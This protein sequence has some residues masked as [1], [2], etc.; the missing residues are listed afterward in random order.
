MT[1]LIEDHGLIG[2]LHTAGL[3][4]R[5][6]TI[7]WLCLPRF[8]SGACFASLLGNAS[9]GFWRVAPVGAGQA[10]RRSYRGNTLILEH[11]W[12]MP[13]GSVKV[14]D[15][16]PPGSVQHDLVRI[17]EG[18]SGTVTMRSE[19]RLRFDYGR[20]VP[21]V[22]RLDGMIVGVAGPD[23]VALHS[24]VP[25][26]GRSLTTY[27]DFSVSAGDHVCFVLAW[28]PSHLSPPEPVDPLDALADTEQFWTSW[29]DQCSYDGP[30]RDAVMRSLLTLKALTYAPTGGI[31]AAPTTSLPESIGGVRNWDYRYCWLRDSAFTLDAFIRTGYVDEARSWRDWLI[32]AVG[33]NPGDLQIMYGLGGERR[34]A[35][36]ELDWLGGYESSRPV[37]VGN[38]AAHQVQLDVYGEVIDTLA[39]AY[40]HGLPL[41][42]HTWGLL[43]KLLVYLDRSWVEPDEGIWE[44]RGQRRDFVYSKV[45]AWVA[46]DRAVQ[47]I[48]TAGRPGQ[49]GRWKA[50]RATIHD[51]ILKKG[52]DTD[53][54][55][56]T[57]AYGH[58]ELDASLL[59]IPLV[60]F[61][62]PD[63]PRVIGTVDAV[64]RELSL[65]SGLVLRYRTEHGVD[66]LPG[67]EGAFL[68][69]TFWL[70]EALHVTGRRDQARDL[71]EHVLSLRNDLGLLAE[72]YDPRSGRMVGNFPQAFSHIP[73]VAAAHL[74]AELPGPATG[75]A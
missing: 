10:S 6:G 25:T 5:D 73:L 41:E 32:R 26:Y 2:D 38:S 12:D 61:L 39:R 55:T 30:Y 4:D 67:D 43:E 14:I 29:A 36:H 72:E 69:C 53:R 60:G 19:L 70:V 33:G 22:H 65:D 16:M 11:V 20:S 45:M 42:R 3:V 52:F 71:F 1:G 49:V 75:L 51:D 13:G 63:D 54:N 68:A 57:Q 28:N 8:D 31:V 59:R 47:T 27:S 35:E 7:D 37:R 56:F 24:D 58:A 9:N 66:G 40:Q 17:V 21:W 23:S 44:I 62:A 18:L 15:F 64:R 46:V 34:L 74:L 50:L 48:H